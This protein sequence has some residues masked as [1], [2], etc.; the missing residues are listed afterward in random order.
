[1]EQ[2]SLLFSGRRDDV[3]GQARSSDQPLNPAFLNDEGLNLIGMK[4]DLGPV[5]HPVPDQQSV[6]L[7][8]GT[9]RTVLQ[10]IDDDRADVDDE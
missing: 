10:D 9:V 1:M 6:V 3:Q 4:R 2:Q 5:Q 8:D 7:Q